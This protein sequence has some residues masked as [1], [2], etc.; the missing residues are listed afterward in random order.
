MVGTSRKS[1]IG[2]ILNK[3]V[4]ERLYGTIATVVL[5]IMNGASIVR[6]HDVKEIK[7]AVVIT[8]RILHNKKI[9]LVN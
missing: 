8:D 2:N 3:P 6:V 1:F 5:S 9:S 4:N 7:D